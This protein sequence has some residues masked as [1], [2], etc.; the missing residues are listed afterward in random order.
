MAS[1]SKLEI[2]ARGLRLRC[3]RC[4][5][6]KIFADFWNLRRFCPTCHLRL[7]RAQGYFVGAIYLN[8]AATIAIV[9]PGYFLLDHFTGAS[10]S[11][12][13]ISWGTVAAVF[14]VI[15]FRYSKG[16]WLGLGYL[17]DSTDA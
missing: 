12:Q 1:Q 17:F 10:L 11:T 7:E 16:L 4:G 13:L 14:P 6:S 15:F 9:V 3:P 8:Y 2:L 5:T